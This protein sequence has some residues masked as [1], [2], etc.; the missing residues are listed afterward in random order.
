MA[1]RFEGLESSALA[2]FIDEIRSLAR[3]N[4]SDDSFSATA[5]LPV[6]G[7]TVE[8]D[9]SGAIDVAAERRRLEKDLASAERELA[10]A[11]AKLSSDG[12]LSKA[13]A[14]TIDNIRPRRG[15][16]EADVVTMRRRL[17][18]LPKG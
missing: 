8:L 18:A 4:A 3:L 13:P 14:D 17:D 11:D 16:A 2:G 5:S 9:L 15:A 7:V 12:F 6:A 1:A 10:Q